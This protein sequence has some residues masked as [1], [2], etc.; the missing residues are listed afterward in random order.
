MQLYYDKLEDNRT[1]HL[2]E[3]LKVTL[4]QKISISCRLIYLWIFYKKNNNNNVASCSDNTESSLR[5]L[6]FGKRACM[7]KC[8]VQ[9]HPSYP[10][11]LQSY[12]YIKKGMPTWATSLITDIFEVKLARQET[13]AATNNETESEHLKRKNTKI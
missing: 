9:N 7:I 1:Q 10:Q 11:Y 3:R 12:I 5:T 2:F 4:D 6:K 8:L 13:V